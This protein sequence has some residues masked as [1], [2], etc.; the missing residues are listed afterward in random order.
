MYYQVTSAAIP[1]IYRKNI[2]CVYTLNKCMWFDNLIEAL[3]YRQQLEE[4]SFF[5]IKKEKISIKEYRIM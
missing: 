4:E 3:H 1:T 2:Y 5:K